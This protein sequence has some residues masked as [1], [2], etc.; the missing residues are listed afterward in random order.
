MQFLPPLES[1]AFAGLRG[2]VVAV[3]DPFPVGL[4]IPL[5]EALLDGI[6]VVRELVFI[7]HY[8][9]IVQDCMREA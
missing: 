7:R 6:P 5:L 4:H 3:L 2:S 1:R 8:Y 9:Y